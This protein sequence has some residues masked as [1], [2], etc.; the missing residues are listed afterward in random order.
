MRSC[1]L[2]GLKGVRVAHIL[3]TNELPAP[4]SSWTIALQRRITMA[5]FMK[6]YFASIEDGYDPDNPLHGR[7]DPTL[8]TKL[9]DFVNQAACLVFLVQGAVSY[10]RD[11]QKLLEMPSRSRDIMNSY[12]LSTDPFLAFLD[13]SCVVGDYFVGSRELLDEYNNGNRKVDGKEVGRLVKIDAS[14]LKRMMQLRGFEE[15]NKARTLGFSEFGATR[16]YKGLRLKTDVELEN[17]AE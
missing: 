14:Q 7:A 17:D 5:Y 9:S 4:E 3:C 10:F 16:G 6:R 8:M 1:T 2:T 13:N 12:Q 11:G 15:P